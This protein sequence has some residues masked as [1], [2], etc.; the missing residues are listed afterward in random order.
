MS[1]AETSQTISNRATRSRN[2]M[3]NGKSI[4]CAQQHTLV[5]GDDATRCNNFVFARTLAKHVAISSTGVLVAEVAAGD[6]IAGIV[7]MDVPRLPNIRAKSVHVFGSPSSV[8][9]L[10]SVD[11]QYI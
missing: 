7:S 4:Q 8:R 5:D 11:T 3:A 6:T 1:E 10:I 9:S 2:D